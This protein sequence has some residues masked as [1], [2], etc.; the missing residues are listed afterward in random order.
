MATWFDNLH[1]PS[2]PWLCTLRCHCTTIG[3][4]REFK[5]EIEVAFK[6]LLHCCCLPHV[7]KQWHLLQVR[8]VNIV[9]LLGV[10]LKPMCLVFPRMHRTLTAALWG[11]PNKDPLD[12]AKRLPALTD[13]YDSYAAACC[14]MRTA[15][16][17]MSCLNYCCFCC[18]NAD[19]CPLPDKLHL[20]SCGVMLDMCLAL[21]HLHFLE[22]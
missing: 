4:L 7:L 14:S 21:H 1:R 20:Y 8:H 2:L 12:A 3:Y 10:C 13:S 18:A 22:V 16:L 15:V 17:Q 11:T 19:Q 5:A 6:V 9:P